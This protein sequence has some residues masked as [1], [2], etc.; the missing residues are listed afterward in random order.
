MDILLYVYCKYKVHSIIEFSNCVS[1]TKLA[2]TRYTLLV[3][4]LYVWCKYKIYFRIITELTNHSNPTIWIENK[5]LSFI[6]KIII[7]NHILKQINWKRVLPLTD[8]LNILR[9]AW[10][11]WWLFY[12]SVFVCVCLSVSGLAHKRLLLE[13]SELETSN[14]F[15]E[16][17]KY[18]FF[19]E[20]LLSEHTPIL[21]FY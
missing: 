19:F 6:D 5:Q 4:T 15:P 8:E 3:F 14:L 1:G 17:F 2:H 13:T 20:K 9:K 12:F 7:T 10:Y 21:V 18:M 11:G 16:S